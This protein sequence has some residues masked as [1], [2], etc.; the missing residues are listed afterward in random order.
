V[1]KIIAH[2]VFATLIF[3]SGS[4]LAQEETISLKEAIATLEATH[5]YT[6]NYTEETIGGY[7]VAII[8]TSLSFVENIA[9]LRKQTS[10]KFTILDNKLVSIAGE[11]S[12]TICGFIKDNATQETIA[13]ATVQGDKNTAVTDGN[14][15]FNLK[16]SA[17][18][19]L[20]TVRYLGYNT[21]IVQATA[22]TSETC[23]TLSLE[24]KREQLNA[25]LLSSYLVQG[26]SK[27]N[28]GALQIDFDN[29]TALPGLIETD[30][31]QTVQALPGIQSTN[32]T[33][34]N[35]NIR[36]GTNDQNLVLWDDIK[37]YQT[38]HFFGLISAFNPQ[39]TEE[40]TVQKNGTSASYTDG[41]SGSILMKTERKINR[42]FKASVGA[43]LVDANIFLD[44]PLGKTSSLQVGGRK[45]LSDLVTTPTYDAYF[46]RISQDTEVESNMG[47]IKNTDRSFDFYDVSLRWLYT[48]GTKDRLRVNFLYIDNILAFNE[49]ATLNESLAPRESSVAQNSLGAGILWQRDWNDKVSSTFQVYESDYNL[50]AINANILEEQRFLQENSVSETGLK[51]FTTITVQENQT[52]LFGYEFIETKVTNLDDVDVPLVRTL[53]AEVVRTHSGFGQYTLESNNKNS[54]LIAG[55][56]YNYLDKFT[57]SILEP[58]LRFTQKFLDHFSFGVAG[59]FKHQITSQVVNFQNDFL[60]IEKR[61]WQLSNNTTIPILKSKQ[62]SAELNFSNKGWLLSAAGYYKYVDGITSQ[63]QGFQNQF[64]FIKTSG[65]YSVLGVDVLFRKR[66]KDISFWLSYSF[67][68]NLYEFESLATDPF[69]SNYDIPHSITFGTTYVYENLKVTAGLN[70]RSGNPTTSPVDG[71][72]IV[73]GTINYNAPNSD[74]FEDYLRID[75]SA[76]YQY[77][78]EST[79][80]EAGISVWNLLNQTNTISNLYR[81]SAEGSVEENKQNSLGL[82]PNA[83]LRVTL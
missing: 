54:I 60:G 6:F 10:L 38:G 41:V 9:S 26:I 16:V 74:R 20:I 72:E 19:E 32:E 22:F 33:V 62:A 67:M 25:V 3:G 18:N 4:A 13:F 55:F 83:M 5:G 49:N 34:S 50:R 69:P 80:I 11:D 39:I 17:L 82:T 47:Q 24:P 81:I 37:M 29:F 66:L 75:S 46:K 45:S 12:L 2:I 53:I 36:G 15:F 14:G 59:E 63:E 65:S 40:V 52:L 23:E 56:R 35:I 76:L 70:W 21:A 28:N 57:E 27:L 42:K 64:E 71:E 73:N 8:D 7:T 43:N 31:L 44:I 77:T 61:R 48:I 1:K 78:F 58:R 68:N 51:A 79:T 30:V